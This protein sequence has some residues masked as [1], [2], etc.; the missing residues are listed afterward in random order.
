[1]LFSRI[2]SFIAISCWVAV[3]CSAQT[4]FQDH[5]EKGVKAMNSED[6]VSATEAFQDA[7]G[8]DP[9]SLLAWQHLANARMGFYIWLRQSSQVRVNVGTQAIMAWQQAVNRD[10]T[11]ELSLWGMAASHTMT[12]DPVKAEEWCGR[13]LAAHPDSR[14]G[15]YL[16]GVLAWMTSY[17]AELQ[18]RGAAGLPPFSD[19][20]IEDQEARQKTRQSNEARLSKAHD[21][22]MH[23]LKVDPE[24]ANA[25]EY[26]G[27]ILR[28]QANFAET[29]GQFLAKNA[30]AA[31]WV[32]RGKKTR[33]KQGDPA[34]PKFETTQPPPPY[35]APEPP[36]PSMLKVQ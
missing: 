8:K 34:F 14:D 33:A 4:T 5:L 16:M 10:P 29:E 20:P 15:N 19:G 35:P 26:V 3:L 27:L 6:V 24:F 1:M 12:G 32:A 18:F 2:C 21:S 30:E 9:N 28:L 22:L 36:P 7:T 17:R 23:A 13:L 11:N 25:M 31:Q